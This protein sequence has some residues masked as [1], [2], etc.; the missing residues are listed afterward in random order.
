M[1]IAKD[2]I[3]DNEKNIMKISLSTQTDEL[4]KLLKEGEKTI[5][6][7]DISVMREVAQNGNK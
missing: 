1:V 5:K 3:T 2:Y 7:R 4:E 6:T